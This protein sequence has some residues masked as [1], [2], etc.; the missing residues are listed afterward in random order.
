LTEPFVVAIT[1]GIASGKSAV[2]RRFEARGVPVYD[3]DMAAREVVAPGTPGLAQI[4]EAFGEEVMLPQGR[5][6]RRALRMR[7]FADPAAR[8][9]LEAI[10]HPL[11]GAWLRQKV[12]EDDGPYA[13]LAIPLLAETWPRYDWVD[14]VLVVDAPGQLRIQ[15]LMQ[16]DEIDATLARQMLKAQ[17]TREDR[18]KLADDVIDNRGAESDL[19]AQVEQLHRRYLEMAA[20]K[21]AAA[22][23]GGD[24]T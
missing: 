16:R 10:V 5:L 3:A 20:A 9:R 8:H 14:R 21:R 18:L 1:G 19:D 23:T 13:M 24:V 11:V 4:A 7:V 12:R 17:S 22:P 15:R 6:D 2:S